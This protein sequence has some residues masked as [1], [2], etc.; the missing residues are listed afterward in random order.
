[1]GSPVIDLCK[2]FAATI[3]FSRTAT[4][5]SQL[6]IGIDR[7]S[8]RNYG[9]RDFGRIPTADIFNIQLPL[10]IIS[11]SSIAASADEGSGIVGAEVLAACGFPSAYRAALHNPPAGKERD[12]RQ[13]EEEKEERETERP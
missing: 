9:K 7:G 8:V 6:G 13:E 11:L 1:M 3:P 10:S 4:Y 12:Q 5:L 2:T